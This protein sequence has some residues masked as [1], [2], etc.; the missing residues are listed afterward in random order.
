MLAT[1]SGMKIILMTKWITEEGLYNSCT[2][3]VF[4]HLSSAARYDSHVKLI[5][6]LRLKKDC[7][8]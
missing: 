4:S 1:M 7:A 5:R 8:D 3:V 2:S 6:T